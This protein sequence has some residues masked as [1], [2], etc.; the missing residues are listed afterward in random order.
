[1]PESSDQAEQQ[2]VAFGVPGEQAPS[3]KW[4]TTDAKKEDKNWTDL[5]QVKRKND[6]RWL[7]VYGWV[8]LV[9]TIV[10]A[11]IFLVA[12][13]SWAWHY[14]TPKCWQWLVD[15]QLSKI[16]SILFSG[17]MGAIISGIIRNQINKA[18]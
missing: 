8:L 14:L 10:F 15:A 13:L 1:M 18:H 9:I 16:Q 2:S 3:P 12:F 11:A 17:G 4:A 5:D 7:T 6:K